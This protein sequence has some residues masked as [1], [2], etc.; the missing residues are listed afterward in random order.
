MRVP[1]MRRRRMMMMILTTIQF[2]VLIL[3]AEHFAHI[4]FLSV[5]FLFKIYLFLRVQEGKGQ[6][7]KRDR[8]S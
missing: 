1:L 8:R 4:S 3:H 7:V 5:F 2:M 6:R